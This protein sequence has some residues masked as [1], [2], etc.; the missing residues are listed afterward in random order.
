MSRLS[1]PS[2]LKHELQKSNATAPSRC[3]RRDRQTLEEDGPTKAQPIRLEFRL[4][5]NYEEEIV[6]FIEMKLEHEGP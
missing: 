4:V 5:T 2:E 6:R 1:S 3:S